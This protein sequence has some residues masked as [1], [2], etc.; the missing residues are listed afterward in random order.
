MRI[1]VIGSGGREHA[2]AWRLAHEHSVWVAPGNPGIARE[3]LCLP[4]VSAIDFAAIQQTCED[5]KIDLVVVGPEDP[6][7]MGLTDFLR[8]K[9]IVAFGPG[10]E[11]AQ[12]EGSKIFAKELMKEAGVA[13]A[14]FQTFADPQTAKEYVR[15]R[16]ADGF[17]QVIKAAGN[18]LGKGVTVAEDVAEAEAAIN[19]MMVQ[20]VFGAAGERIVIEDR[21]LGPEFSLITLVSDHDYLS[22]PV[23][24]DHKRVNDGDHGPNTGGMGVYLPPAHI[25]AEV[26]ASVEKQ[27]VEPV[28]AALRQRGI[29]YRGTLF[30]GLMMHH[31]RP[32]C[33][34]FNVR[35]GDPETQALMMVI[36]DGFG[37]AL[38][39]A[40]TGEALSPFMLTHMAAVHVVMS[41]EGYP[42][43]VRRGDPI[44]EAPL[45]EGVKVFFAGVGGTPEHLVTAGGRVLGVSATSTEIGTAREAVYTALR[46]FGIPGAHYRRDIAAGL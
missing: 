16:F 32:H 42:G 15:L 3:I 43:P 4:Q 6:L 1:L 10:R 2:L 23:A 7:V 17:P 39:A 18:A 41:A 11:A 45:P 21:L 30:S 12:L 14:A 22:L 35:F 31:G 46:S 9:G 8:A 40:A 33:L 24:Q 19:A 36:G 5:L 44:V 20:R 27:V 38:R 37:D 25:D 13:T 28:L 26:V 34:E 29:A